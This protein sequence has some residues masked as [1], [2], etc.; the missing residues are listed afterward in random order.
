ML[1]M[2]EEDEDE[3]QDIIDDALYLFKPHMFFRTFPIKGAADRVVLYVTMYLH[4]CLKKIV[5][6]TRDEASAVLLNYATTSFASPGEDE[7]LFNAF[8]STGTEAEKEKWREYAKQLRLEATVRLL[9][10]VFLFPEKD[11]TGSKFWMSFAK[12]PFL[13][14]S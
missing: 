12:R 14:S 10:K 11:G 13:A 5:L 8:F 2:I 1:D 9:E 6:L 4:E 7:F 3:P